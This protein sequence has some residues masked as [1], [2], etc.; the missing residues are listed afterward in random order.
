ML[1]YPPTLRKIRAK[2]ITNVRP[3]EGKLYSFR[4]FWPERKSRPFSP[5]RNLVSRALALHLSLNLHRTV[6][7]RRAHISASVADATISTPRTSINWKSSARFCAKICAASRSWSY[8]VKLLRIPL[9][10]GTI[11]IVH[12]CKFEHSLSFAPDTLDS[13]RTSF[14]PSKIARSVPL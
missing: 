9:R 12:G 5:K 7:R 13:H 11:A 10:P 14:F 4:S 6:S 3:Q 2:M 1:A 8:D